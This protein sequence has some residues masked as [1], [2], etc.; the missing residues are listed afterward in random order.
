MNKI[1]RNLAISGGVILAALLIAPESVSQ[2][3]TKKTEELKYSVYLLKHDAVESNNPSWIKLSL[4][5]KLQV[6]EHFE[7]LS[8][9][10]EIESKIEYFDKNRNATLDKNYLDGKQYRIELNLFNTN[11]FP[12]K[13]AE[14]WRLYRKIGIGLKGLEDGLDD[15]KVTFPFK[16]G[17]EVPVAD[18]TYFYIQGVDDFKY[19]N[20]KLEL[21]L[22]HKF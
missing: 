8:G 13:G 3:K 16:L 1:A 2:N 5:K 15:S 21:G 20:L 22:K 18:K 19:D 9:G 12:L 4:S 11:S 7:K 14:A 17:V 10:F 6:S